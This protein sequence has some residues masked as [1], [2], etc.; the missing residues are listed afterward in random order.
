[1]TRDAVAEVMAPGK[2]GRRPVGEVVEARE[3]AAEAA[4]RDSDRQR[5][6]ETRAGA[7]ADADAAL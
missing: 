1:M 4:D 6:R 3:V 7:H 5:Q 2:R